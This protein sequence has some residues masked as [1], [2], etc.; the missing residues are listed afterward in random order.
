[1]TDMING[2]FMEDL[3]TILMD[4]EH[5]IAIEVRVGTDSKISR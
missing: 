1:M 4:Q 5:M 2:A 3:L